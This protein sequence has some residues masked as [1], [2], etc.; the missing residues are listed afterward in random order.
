MSLIC[1]NDEAISVRLELRADL[2]A[3]GREMLEIH[4]NTH[5]GGSPAG[6]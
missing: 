2:V 5:P 4:R 1:D 6:R 3:I